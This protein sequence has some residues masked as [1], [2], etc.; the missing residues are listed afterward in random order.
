[1]TAAPSASPAPRRCRDCYGAH[2]AVPGCHG[3]DCAG[4]AHRGPVGRSGPAGL[5]GRAAPVAARSV[6]LVV[7]AA[8]LVHAPQGAPVGCWAVVPVARRAV[9]AVLVRPGAAACSGAPVHPAAAGAGPVRPAPVVHG[10]VRDGPCAPRC[11][12]PGAVHPEVPL[13]VAGA[14]RQ[15]QAVPGIVRGREPARLAVAVPDVAQGAREP[16]AAQRGAAVRLPG[17]PAARGVRA[18]PVAVPAAVARA[19]G[20]GPARAPAKAARSY[21]AALSGAPGR[22]GSGVSAP[23]RPRANRTRVLRAQALRPRALRP[24][25]PGAAVAGASPPPPGGRRRAGSRRCRRS[26]PAGCA[27]SGSPGAGPGPPGPGSSTCRSALRPRRQRSGGAPLGT[28]ASLTTR[29]CFPC[30]SSRSGGER[31]ASAGRPASVPRLRTRS[32][33]RRSQPAPQGRRRPRTMRGCRVPPRRRRGPAEHR[34]PPGSVRP[35]QPQEHTP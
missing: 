8:G 25:V 23:A 29:C 28:R 9:P 4:P 11:A 3:P 1:M 16:A 35:H 17:M 27:R 6:A 7:Q 12:G 34:I 21:R 32:T 30:Y 24:R 15:A 31:P 22:R 2:S 13:A 26:S 20:P 10:A 33:R 5:P 14:V 19:P 18:P